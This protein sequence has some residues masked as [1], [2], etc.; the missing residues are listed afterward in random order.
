MFT[1]M[2]VGDLKPRGYRK[3]KIPLH[4]THKMTKNNQRRKEKKR[5][6][7]RSK[8]R[9]RP[10]ELVLANGVGLR[11]GALHDGGEERE[12]VDVAVVVGGM[13]MVGGQVIGVLKHHVSNV[14][15]RRLV[16]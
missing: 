13:E 16:R 10:L 9:Q 7:E 3:N 12:G 15:S 1:P 4:R 14:R 5:N 11:C 8:R 2:S 6:R